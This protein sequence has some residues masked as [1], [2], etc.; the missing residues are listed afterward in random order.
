M[1]SFIDL[2]QLP[3]VG[4][5]YEFVGET[6]GAPFS[7][8]IV[9]AEPGQGRLYTSIPTSKPRLRSKAALP[10]RSATNSAR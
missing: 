8:Y 3:F 10:S 4:M 2:E 9:K 7:A 1:M 5:S 6:Q